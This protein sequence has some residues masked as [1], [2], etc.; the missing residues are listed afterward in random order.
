MTRRPTLISSAP[1]PAAG[2]APTP[3]RSAPVTGRYSERPNGYELAGRAAKVARVVS[4]L[5]DL[6]RVSGCD[7]RRDA[8]LALKLIVGLPAPAWR[9]AAVGAGQ[10]PLSERSVEAAIAVYAERAAKGAA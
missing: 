8:V 5:D 3:T 2:S 7:P 6:L 9:T 10:R 4:Y 1:P